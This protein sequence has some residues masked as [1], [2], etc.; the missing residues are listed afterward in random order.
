MANVHLHYNLV[1]WRL[2]N[3]LSK[4]SSRNVR[5]SSLLFDKMEPVRGQLPLEMLLTARTTQGTPLAPLQ[6]M[7]P[8]QHPDSCDLW[9]K[10]C[11]T[12]HR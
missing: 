2:E 3:F 11:L 5:A 1:H 10:C 12:R 9:H 7:G 8:F 6:S 4:R